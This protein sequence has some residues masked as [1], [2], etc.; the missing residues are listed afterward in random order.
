MFFFL[1]VII[2]NFVLYFSNFRS[3][4]SRLRVPEDFVAVTHFDEENW[5]CFFSVKDE[6]EN[7]FPSSDTPLLWECKEKKFVIHGHGIVNE[8]FFFF[9]FFFFIQTDAEILIC[10][11]SKRETLFSTREDLLELREMMPSSLCIRKNHGFFLMS[12]DLNETIK[13][14]VKL[15][16]SRQKR[17]FVLGFGGVGRILSSLLSK[18]SLISFVIVGVCDSSEFVCDKFGIDLNA[19]LKMKLE[20]NSLNGKNMDLLNVDIIKELKTDVVLDARPFS[21]TNNNQVK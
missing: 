19:N 10:S 12:N 13:C 18:Q 14:V 7:V 1:V 15:L 8:V 5:K 11:I 21:F 2:Q 16:E 20:T 6:K 3:A 17:V 4:A 9:F